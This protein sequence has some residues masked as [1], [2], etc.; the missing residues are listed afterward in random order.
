MVKENRILIFILGFVFAW[1]LFFASSKKAISQSTIPSGVAFSGE[2]NVMYFLDRS[3]SKIYRYNVQGR[4]TR[5][6]IIE[7]LGE[8]LRL[9]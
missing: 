1:I 5:T 7:E 4:L 8:D 3:D 6:Y 9:R 2:S